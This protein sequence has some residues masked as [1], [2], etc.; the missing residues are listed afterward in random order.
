M[1]LS[2]ATYLNISFANAVHL[3]PHIPTVEYHIPRGKKI[4]RGSERHFP[5]EGIIHML[6]ERDVAKQIST[7]FHAHIFS[8]TLWH[9]M[10]QA[11][12][13]WHCLTPAI[14]NTKQ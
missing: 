4:D 10:Y 12:S 5:E 6:E 9:V 3:S 13:T 7:L 14:I 11:L 1:R 8:H 2:V